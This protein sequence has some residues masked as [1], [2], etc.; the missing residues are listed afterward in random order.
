M[1]TKRARLGMSVQEINAAGDRLDRHG[2]PRC[3]FTYADGRQCWGTV[4]RAR[5][6]GPIRDQQ[7]VERTDVRKYRFWCDLKDDHAG[8]VSSFA[9]KERMEFYPDELPPGMEDQIWANDI[10]G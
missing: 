10:L 6:Y 2:C 3:L 8:A 1:L 4:Y 9:A 7:S 5:A